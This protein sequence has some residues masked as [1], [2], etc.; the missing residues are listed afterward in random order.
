MRL[1]QVILIG[2]IGAMLWC[3]GCSKK[4]REGFGESVDVFKELGCLLNEHAA[5]GRY[6]GVGSSFEYVNLRLCEGGAGQI[7][8]ISAFASTTNTSML[9]WRLRDDGFII[10]TAPDMDLEGYMEG[11]PLPSRFSC[12]SGNV[13]L[14]RLN[15]YG[16]DYMKTAYLLRDELL[17]SMRATATGVVSRRQPTNDLTR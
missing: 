13:G 5:F 3:G 7:T 14:I 1:A 15:I 8:T 4:P 2:A 9:T 6:E 12:P 17:T 16:Y 11:M 10:L